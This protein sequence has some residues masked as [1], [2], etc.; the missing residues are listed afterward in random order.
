MW[1]ARRQT[2]AA[3]STC[4]AEYVAAAGLAT[5]ATWLKPL[6]EEIFPI[7]KDAPIDRQM[8]NQSALAVVN[9]STVSTRNRHFPIKQTSLREAIQAGVVKVIYTPTDQMIADGPT[10]ALPKAKF[11]EFLCRLGMTKGECSDA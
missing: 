11:D 7:E 1:R 2:L 4:E 8:D 3:Q 9:G 5:I 10:K 6:F